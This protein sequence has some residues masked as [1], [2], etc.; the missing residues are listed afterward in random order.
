MWQ[1]RRRQ[2]K[3]SNAPLQVSKKLGEEEEEGGEEKEIKKG[4]GRKFYQ[5]RKEQA[6][7]KCTADCQINKYKI[8]DSKR[9]RGGGEGE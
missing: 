7:C 6:T 8:D 4:E 1:E 3:Q 9:M 2:G 5:L